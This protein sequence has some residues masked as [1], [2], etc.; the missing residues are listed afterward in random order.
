MKKTAEVVV[1]GGG[2]S[3]AP[4]RITLPKKVSKMWC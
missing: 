1:I 2:I 4:L 3:G